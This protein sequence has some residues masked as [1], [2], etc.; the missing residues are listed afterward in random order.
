MTD[1]SVRLF[2]LLEALIPRET[3]A[4]DCILR[5]L[6]WDTENLNLNCSA[7]AALALWKQNGLAVP[8]FD[9]C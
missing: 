3:R 9:L 5:F 6:R 7:V 1:E 2:H 8:D 4:C